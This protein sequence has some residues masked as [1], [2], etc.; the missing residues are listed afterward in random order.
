MG[1]IATPRERGG[2]VPSRAG[3]TR[4]KSVEDTLKEA[5]E[6]QAAAVKS[7][8]PTLRTRI[9]QAG[10][11]WSNRFYYGICLAAAGFSAFFALLILKF[12]PIA[13]IG[14]AITGGL[15]LPHM[16]VSRKRNARFQAFTNEFPTA[17]DLIVRGIRS[18]LPVVDCLKIV[19]SET[20][21]P[22]RSEFKLLVE[23]QTLGAPLDQAVERMA[24]RI[25]IASS[26]FF[27]IVIAIQSRTGGNL[28]EALGN[29]SRVLR[30]RKK[31]QAKIKAVSSEAKAS[32]MI[33][34]SLPVFVG[35]AV[36]LIARDY[37]ML[38]F[39]TS[40]GNAVLIFCGFWMLI[41]TFIMRKMIN[42]D[43]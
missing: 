28:S 42:F 27:A 22:V 10:L 41:G 39:S 24:D 33:I 25:P 29:L 2:A 6:Q 5:V 23:D 37:M 19:A 1:T 36:Y 16:Y 30:E 21:D 40:T 8:K 7:N 32:A 9:R 4:R 38:L 15:L 12:G 14:F 26:R 43:I 18:G 17:I 35:G 3:S 34:A 31:M 20:Q 11:K 13:T